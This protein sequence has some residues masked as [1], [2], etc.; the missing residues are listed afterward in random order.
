MLGHIFERSITEL[1]KLRVVGLFGKQAGNA[2]AAMPKNAE[3]KRFGIYYT[4]PQFTRLI[5]E[6]T[7]GKLIAERVETLP[8]LQATRRRTAQAEGRRSRLRLG[9]ISDRRVRAAGRRL[10]GDRPADAHCRPS[11]GCPEP[12]QRISRTT[13]S[14]K[15]VRRG[16]FGRIGR[17]H[18]TGPVDSLGPQGPH[19]DRPVEQRP[20]R[21]QPDPRQVRPSRSVRL[22]RRVSRGFR[23]LAASTW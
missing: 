23:R 6:E 14:S 11:P 5:V 22:A 17:D 4:P 19:A 9:R 15:S 10:R 20:P 1:E 16:P 18:A 7:L 8:D 12:H 2:A 21:Q 13:S 3:R